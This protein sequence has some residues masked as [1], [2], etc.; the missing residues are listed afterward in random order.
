MLLFF[1]YLAV[2]TQFFSIYDNAKQYGNYEWLMKTDD[3]TYYV[4]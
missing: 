4:N 1:F 3:N 2:Y